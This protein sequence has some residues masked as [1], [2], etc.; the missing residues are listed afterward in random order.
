MARK[1]LFHKSYDEEQDESAAP[2]SQEKSIE[3]GV[4]PQAGKA[5]KKAD[6]AKDYAKHPKFA[7]FSKGESK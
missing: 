3:A 1:K 5:K 7:K 6:P 4:E 2:E